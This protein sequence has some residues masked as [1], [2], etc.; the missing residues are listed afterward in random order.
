M[1]PIK[2]S[3]NSS[4]SKYIYNDAMKPSPRFPKFFI[5]EILQ[6]SSRDSPFLLP[7][8]SNLEFMFCFYEVACSGH[9]IEVESYSIC[10]FVSGLFHLA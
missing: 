6:P 5:T 3:I 9:F 2:F 8:P 1:C 7:A 4:G 10:H